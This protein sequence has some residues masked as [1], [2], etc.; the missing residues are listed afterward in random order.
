MFRDMGQPP[1]Y[2]NCPDCKRQRTTVAWCKTC[3]V[4]TLKENFCNWTSGYHMID[5]LIRYTQL[6][7]NESMDYL[8]W[9]N[10]DQFDLIK[11]TKIQGAHSSIYSAIWMEGPRWNLDEVVEVWNRNGPIKV[12]LKRLN[13]SHNMSQEFLNQLYRYHKCLQSGALADC[14]GITKDLT[15]HYILVM[16]YYENGNL[17]SYI[18]ESM[19][20]I[21]W[22]DIIDILWSISIGLKFIHEHDLVHKNLHGGNILIENEMGS[23]DAKIADTGLYGPVDEQISSQ[24]IYALV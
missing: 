18:D 22:R 6:N 16:R 14:F 20:N 17:Y 7:A 2:G 5:E 21:C 24:Q 3:D 12:I 4:A 23:I 13:N 19:G 8:E 11:N 9:I 1:L 10:F 15:S